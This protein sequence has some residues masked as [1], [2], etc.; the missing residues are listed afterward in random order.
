[1]NNLNEALTTGPDIAEFE[2]LDF[3]VE[4]F[5]HIAHV[6]VAWQYVRDLDLLEAISRYL[7]T[8]RRL[9]DQLGVPGKYHETLTWF[10]LIKIA[11]QATGTARTDWAVFRRSNP[12]L[13]QR[14]PGLVEAYYSADRLASK[15]A[16]AQFML[17]D[18]VA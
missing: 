5:D 9:T 14:S 13:F 6:Y 17:P 18:R 15:E 2:A 10:Y 3:D 16:R 7:D 1:M 8:L 4:T 12:S 11:E